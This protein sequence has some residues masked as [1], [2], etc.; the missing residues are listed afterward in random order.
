MAMRNSILIDLLPELFPPGFRERERTQA[1]DDLRALWG[2][3]HS[4]TPQPLFDQCFAR[5]LSDTR[6]DRYCVLNIAGVVHLVQ[7]IAEV[8]DAVLQVLL[9]VRLHFR[10]WRLLQFSQNPLCRMMLVLEIMTLFIKP[11]FTFPFVLANRR[12]SARQVL[13]GVVEIQDLLINVGTKKIP[14]GFCAIRNTH[15]M[16]SR[17]QRLYMV[18]LTHHAIEE[19]LFSVL[20]CRPYVNCVQTLAMLVIQRNA[21]RHGFSPLL[22]ADQH[23][24]AIDPDTNRCNLTQLR[25]CVTPTFF[26]GLDHRPDMRGTA[27]WPSGKGGHGSAPS[28]PQPVWRRR[29]QI[30]A[31]RSWQ[32]EALPF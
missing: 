13:T 21:A 30:C 19:C 7:M 25:G 23:A 11:L 29:A 6:S 18:D 10:G 1:W 31:T 28:L 15:E 32:T 9:L 14:I 8:R 20:R 5:S 4:R 2:P 3:A 26:F 27:K 24:G 22:V 17:I 12:R 16:R